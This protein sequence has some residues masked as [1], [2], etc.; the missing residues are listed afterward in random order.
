[1]RSYLS[2]LEAKQA[3]APLGVAGH[4]LVAA[5]LGVPRHSGV[6]DGGFRCTLVVAGAIV[7]NPDALLV[8]L[9]GKLLARLPEHLH[10][11]ASFVKPFMNS[12]FLKPPSPASTSL[13]HDPLVVLD[14]QCQVA[15][16]TCG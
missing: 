14:R 4:R 16:L 11:G 8:A 15:R 10:T 2:V 5:P 13:L 1:M 12:R 3:A 7:V 6:E 9:A